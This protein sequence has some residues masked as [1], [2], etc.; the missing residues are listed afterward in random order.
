M[1]MR[2][3]RFLFFP[4]LFLAIAGISFLVT[5][6]LGSQKVSPNSYIQVLADPASSSVTINDRRAATG[7]NGVNP[8]T[9]TVTISKAG[10]A[11][12]S[13]TVS[14]SLNQT[15][16]V[17]IVLTSNSPTTQNW[18][19]SHQKDQQLQ[20]A[21]G[22]QV[23]DY[24]AQVSSQKNPFIN[25]LPITYGDGQGG[26]ITISLGVSTTLSNGAAVNINAA[27]PELR[28]SALTYLRTRGFDP[29]NMEMVFYN[30]ENPL[31]GVVSE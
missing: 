10:F 24:E 26:F 21:I 9:Y 17:G 28:Q 19:S 22:S 8:G 18:Y 31:G 20:D 1:V 11:S 5:T 15:V 25:Q 16:L 30:E 3:F 7:K 14:V 13:Q 29:A 12:Q 27:S 6:K 4:L 23:T 2:N